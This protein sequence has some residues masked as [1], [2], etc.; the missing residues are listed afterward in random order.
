RHPRRKVLCLVGDGG[1]MMT[2]NEMI[3]A[4]ER[5]LPILFVLSNNGSYASIRI[6]QEHQYPGRVSGTSLHNPDF[7]ALAAAFGMPC[8][9]IEHAGQIDDIVAHAMAQD[10]PMFVEVR[11]S[12]SAV[13]PTVR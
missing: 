8:R 2:G 9:R 4:A 6:H 1:F 10:G 13:L 5:R 12:L 11:S 7:Q 3:A